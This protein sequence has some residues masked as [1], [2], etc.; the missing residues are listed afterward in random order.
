MR[1]LKTLFL[2]SLLLIAAVGRGQ[3]YPRPVGFVN[4]FD[5]L[6]TDS[7]E[8]SLDTLLHR[9][10]R[11][12][13]VEIAVVTLDSSLPGPLPL[14]TYCDSLANR[15]GIGKRDRNNGILIGVCK[16]QRQATIRT[17]K[18][19]EAVL[20]DAAT[21]AVIRDQFVPAF[22]DGA[23]YKGLYQGI[24]ALMRQLMR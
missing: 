10:E 2:F 12:T 11:L 8:A 7:E 21:G 9:Y 14:A 4:D 16:S 5:R 15:W 18:G 3:T 17:G 24:V 13:S 19:L 22:R 23:F 6:L 1:Y 20:P